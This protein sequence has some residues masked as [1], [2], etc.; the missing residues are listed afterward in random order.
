MR[1]VTYPRD[2]NPYQDNL[3][4][5][6]AHVGINADYLPERT[7][8]QTVNLLMLPVELSLARLR[9]TRVV[10]LHWVFRFSLP[11]TQKWSP[12]RHI[13]W[14]WF[15]CVLWWIEIIGLRL[16]WT[17]HNALPHRQVF[18]DDT[19]ARTVLLRHCHALITHSSAAVD[20]ARSRGWSLPPVTVIPHG[21]ALRSTHLVTSP[22]DEHARSVRADLGIPQQ[23]ALVGIVGRIDP[24]KGADSLIDAVLRAG[25]DVRVLIAG[26]CDDEA[27]RRRLLTRAAQ[28]DQVIL[29]LGWLEDAQFASYLS[30]LDVAVLPF[31]S[32]TTSGSAIA[33][34]NAGVP[35]AMPRSAGVTELPDSCVHLYDNLDDAISWIVGLDEMDVARLSQAAISWSAH[36]GWADVARETASV[37]RAAT[38]AERR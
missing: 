19:T 25:D 18:P 28:S 6:L 7:A 1:I 36:W 3:H 14:W 32:V 23:T 16:V 35:V 2:G 11:W 13:T 21:P 26:R 22:D 30:A 38:R 31:T 10:H 24:Y 8:S 29:K 27:L 9:G 34:L 4:E 33:A 20:Q 37:Y 15:R 12:L 17:M 5:A